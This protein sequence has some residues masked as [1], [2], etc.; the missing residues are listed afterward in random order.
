MVRPTVK[1]IKPIKQ[2]HNQPAKTGANVKSYKYPN[3]SF[4]S[5]FITVWWVSIFNQ[6]PSIDIFSNKLSVVIFQAI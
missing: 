4:L 6:K 2:K 5:W 1:P 3:L